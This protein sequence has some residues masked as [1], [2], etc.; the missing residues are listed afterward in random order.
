[1]TLTTLGLGEV[2]HESRTEIR[3]V[4]F[5]VSGLVS[6]MNAVG[7]GEAAEVAVV[8]NE[9]CVESV[10]FLSGEGSALRRAVVQVAG[11]AYQVKSAAILTEFNKGGAVQHLLL[12]Y[13][14]LLMTQLS[15]TVVC[16]R[17]HTVE[18]R[19]CRWL[20][21]RLERVPLSELRVT[22]EL[23]GNML[24]VRRSGIAQAIMNLQKAGLIEYRRGLIAVSDR[25]KLEAHACECYAV[26]KRESDRLLRLPGPVGALQ[27]E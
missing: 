22:H 18:Q 23:L 26:V 10:I 3:Q 2:L 1:M 17:H 21:Q 27:G 8:G 7:Y 13:V 12:R 4:Y 11:H 25:A 16:N 24:G 19:L 14:Q 6:L 15:Q 9:G 20:L 5:P